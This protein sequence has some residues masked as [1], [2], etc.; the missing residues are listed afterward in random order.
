MNETVKIFHDDTL[1]VTATTVRVPVISSHSEAVN[2]EFENPIEPDEA[3][4]VLSKAA[5]VEVVDDPA[6]SL[7]P[8]ASE[9]TGKDS[10]FVGRIRKD[11]TVSNGLDLWIV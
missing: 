8:L 3:R 1:S 9:A 5:G 10:V 4:K 2:I 7:Y 6:N 11:T